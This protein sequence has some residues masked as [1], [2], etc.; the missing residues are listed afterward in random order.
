GVYE[1][2]RIWIDYGLDGFFDPADEIAA[3]GPINNASTGAFSFVV[4]PTTPAGTYR[5]RVRLVYNTTASTIDP[6]NNYNYGETH[7]YTVNIVTPPPCSG[8]PNAVTITGPT[9]V[10]SGTDF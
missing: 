5:M 1:N 6:C 3:F 9:D 7:D 4:P 10:C 8:Q 2:V